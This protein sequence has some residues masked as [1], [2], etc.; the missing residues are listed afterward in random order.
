MVYVS[1]YSTTSSNTKSTLGPRVLPKLPQKGERVVFRRC[2]NS[3][4][5]L[6]W[7]VKILV[8]LSKATGQISGETASSL[9]LEFF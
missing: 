4:K 2:E 9:H 1:S 7:N 5:C 3:V 8:L 6:K